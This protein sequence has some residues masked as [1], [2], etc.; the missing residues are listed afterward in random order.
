MRLAPTSWPETARS[1][2]QSP[3]VV[4]AAVRPATYIRA[5]STIVCW[6]ARGGSGGVAWGEAVDDGAFGM[7]SSRD[8][9]DG[10]AA[11]GESPTDAAAVQKPGT[12]A[13][14]GRRENSSVAEDRTDGK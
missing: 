3:S 11:R 2:V 9:R 10:F 1:C 13:M 7:A 6:G 14:I 8:R 12:L 4:A 5:R